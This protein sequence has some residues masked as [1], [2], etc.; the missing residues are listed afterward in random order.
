MCRI[1]FNNV[2]IN[3]LW[4]FHKEVMKRTFRIPIR[5][6]VHYLPQRS[7]LMFLKKKIDL[8]RLRFSLQS[9]KI[10]T[11][12]IRLI[13]QSDNFHTFTCSWKFYTE[14]NS[15]E[16]CTTLRKKIFHNSN[17]LVVSVVQPQWIFDNDMQFTIIQLFNCYQ[18]QRASLI[19]I[20]PTYVYCPRSYSFH[21]LIFVCSYARKYVQL[22][23]SLLPNY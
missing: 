17:Y 15:S 6:I 20:F 16:S 11:S 2:L 7:G 12:N 1:K 22:L 9:C 4:S 23:F 10:C 5:I 14:L 3:F 21:A 19:V 18:I 13:V 8:N